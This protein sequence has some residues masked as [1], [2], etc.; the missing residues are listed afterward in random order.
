MKKTSSIMY[1]LGRIFEILEIVVSVFGIFIGFVAATRSEEIYQKIVESGASTDITGPAQVK[2]VGLGMLVTCILAIV[3]GIVV[4]TLLAR[5]KNAVEEGKPARKLHIA[6]IVF[7][8]C[9]NLFILLGGAF[10]L[11][12]SEAVQANPPEEPEQPKQE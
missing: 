10:A 9:T 5:A 12:A 8:L 1:L 6:M 7:G 11:G 3:I 2:E 4:L